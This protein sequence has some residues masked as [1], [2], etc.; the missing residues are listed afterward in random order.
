MYQITVIANTQ[1]DVSKALACAKP[2][3]DRGILD[4]IEANSFTQ[5]IREYQG[6]TSKPLAVYPIHCTSAE[7]NAYF[8]F[9]MQWSGSRWV[10]DDYTQTIF[11]GDEYEEY[12]NE[13]AIKKV[14][15]FYARQQ[16]ANLNRAERDQLMAT[17]LGPIFNIV[18]PAGLN[19]VYAVS[20]IRSPGAIL[21]VDSTQQIP[22]FALSIKTASAG[23]LPNIQELHELETIEE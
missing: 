19:E 22:Q 17:V 9:V 12:L 23:I 20:E 3:M 15:N 16:S 11:V 5:T 8:A 13:D 1:R 18:P 2:F 6:C 21:A 10:D 7:D 4:L 14:I